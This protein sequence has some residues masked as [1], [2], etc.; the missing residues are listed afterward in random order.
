MKLKRLSSLALLAV[1]VIAICSCD[2]NP[3]VLKDGYIYVQKEERRNESTQWQLIWEDD[4]DKGTLDT[5]VWSR[6]GLF[7]SPKWKVPV[8]KW[9]EVNNCFRYITATDPR[10]VQ[11]DEENI[12]LK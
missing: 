9:R 6:I 11:F 10:V 4:F 12:L 7:E 1:I 2:K 3:Y 5:T 8:E